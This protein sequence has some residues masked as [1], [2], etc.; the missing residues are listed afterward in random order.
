[1]PLW[2]HLQPEHKLIALVTYHDTAV[3]EAAV[4]AAAANRL[5]GTLI[6]VQ[7]HYREGR[8]WAHSW[9][10]YSEGLSARSFIR[11]VRLF[12]EISRNALH[13]DP[14]LFCTEVPQ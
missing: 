11:M 14:A 8:L 12:A 5:N 3:I 6:L 13:E 9:L 7:F 2:V 10:S 4:G 1:M